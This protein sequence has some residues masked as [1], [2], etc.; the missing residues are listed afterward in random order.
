ARVDG[1]VLRAGEAGWD[2]AVHVWNAMITK[3]P[4]LVVQPSTVRG[5]AAAIDFV[6]ERGLPVSGKC[7]G[8]NIAGT[9]IADG[10]VVVGPAR[11]RGVR[12]DAGA[13]RVHAGGGCRLADVDEAT[14][15]HGLATPLG[16]ISETGVAGLTLG[17]GFGYLMRRF[18]WSADNLEE[19]EIVTADGRI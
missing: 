7:G 3:T 9:S 2:D 6:R 4:A 13:R 17:G 15:A 19:V 16:F 12:V 18:G 1:A 5:V 11:M 10:G 14:Q 8:H